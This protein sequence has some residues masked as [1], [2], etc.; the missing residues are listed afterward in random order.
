MASV[1]FEVAVLLVNW[2]GKDHLSVCLEH[3]QR[4]QD[5]GCPWQIWVFDNGSKDG[6][7]AWL[8]AHHP[9]VNL[10]ENPVNIGFA[11][12]VNQ[13]V[14]AT[15]AEG[16]V[17][18]NN[19]T[20]PRE[21][22]LANLVHA[23]R[24]SPEDV[25]CVG[26]MALNWTGETIDFVGG[27]LTFD[28]HAYQTQAGLPLN[29]AT[30][31][32]AADPMLFANGANMI[33]RRRAFLEVGGFDKEFFAYFEDVDLGWRFWAKGYR[34][35]FEP[36]AVV[37]HRQQ[38]T[39]SR[40]GLFNRGLLYE[41]NAFLNAYKNF[42]ATYWQ[43]LMPAIMMTLLRRTQTLL[44]QRNPGGDRLAEIPFLPDHQVTGWWRRLKHRWGAF[45]QSSQLPGAGTLRQ[46]SASLSSRMPFFMASTH[47]NDPWTLAQMRAVHGIFDLLD[48]Y[49]ARRDQ[50]QRQRVRPDREIFD[51]F[52]LKIVQTYPGDAAFFESQAFL[53]LL[54]DFATFG[55]AYGRNLYAGEESAN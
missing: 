53:Q 30:I 17:L 39:S 29:Q 3:L 9:Q 49:A 40:L 47:I 10:L 31:P 36:G 32:Q 8:K 12:A 55:L 35:V 7:Q 23:L 15:E 19:D 26:G 14:L 5:P 48:L 25:V 52:S 54:P 18:L 6:S 50:V 1:P 2:N 4:Q 38:A 51:R 28:G 37:H 45:L 46:I 11:E 42:D 21:D 34:V 22:W 13:L 20:A 43:A 33:V 16:L 44:E 41:R 27:A 24:N